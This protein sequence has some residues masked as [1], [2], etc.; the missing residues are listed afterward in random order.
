MVLV[1]LVFG[2]AS[3]LAIRAVA[4]ICDRTVPF[5]DGP[6]PGRPPTV[7]LIGGATMVGGLLASRALPFPTLAIFLILIVSL[8][9]CWYS[10]VRCGIVPDYF[11]LGPLAIVLMA[12]LVT[13]NFA[14]LIAAAVVFLPFAIA[15]YVS[16][17][18]GMGWGDVK[19][20]T[21][22]AAV[23]GLNTSV[24]AFTM[25]CLAA[26][27]IA[28][29]RRRRSEPI[30]FAPYLAGSIAVAIAIPAFP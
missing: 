23:L 13:R 15:A 8:A 6:R 10:D 28:M 21:L 14:P 17:G 9:A 24:L 3:Y 19:I 18:R 1:A 25:A 11:T 30:A 29:V 27:A 2:C 26:Y 16:K 5:E 7:A 12:A 22:G 4:S 20:V